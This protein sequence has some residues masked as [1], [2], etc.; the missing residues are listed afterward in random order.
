MGGIGR[1]PDK[2]TRHASGCLHKTASLS[3]CVIDENLKFE[4]LCHRQAL[5]RQG[6]P[7]EIQGLAFQSPINSRSNEDSEAVAIEMH[8]V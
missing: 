8:K 7:F 6:L 2:M 5:M 3:N 4:Q 1:P